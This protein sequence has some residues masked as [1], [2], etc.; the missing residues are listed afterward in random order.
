MWPSF[1]SGGR[2]QQGVMRPARGANGSR[3]RDSA[4][5]G[6]ARCSGRRSGCPPV[7]GVRRC[8]G[9]AARPTGRPREPSAQ[10][11]T[12]GAGA[13]GQEGGGDLSRYSAHSSVHGRRGSRQPRPT[14]GPRCQRRRRCPRRTSVCRRRQ[15]CPRRAGRPRR[16][17]LATRSA[18]PPC[19]TNS[20]R[21][22]TRAPS[23]GRGRA[24]ARRAARSPAH[25]LLRHKQ[26]EGNPG[27]K[28]PRARGL[29]A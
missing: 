10:S 26:R 4:C 24:R 6:E 15:R 25:R 8:C 1:G 23:A 20:P 17:R 7:R 22:A 14:R 5:K 3:A 9:P 2:R 13:G 12:A 21:A 11:A 28:G 19:K 29:R 18:A 27:R 16:G